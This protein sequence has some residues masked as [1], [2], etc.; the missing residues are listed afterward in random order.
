MHVGLPH[1][2]SL[3]AG[4]LCTFGSRCLLRV[5][6]EPVAAEAPAKCVP[7]H[8]AKLLER[9]VFSNNELGRPRRGVFDLLYAVR[10]RRLGYK[11]KLQREAHFPPRV[12][13]RL[14]LVGEKLLP[15]LSGA[16]KQSNSNL[17]G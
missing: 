17:N 6:Q 10:G 4:L 9:Q 5:F 7:G 13:G 16:H 3:E 1:F 14:G 15:H 12:P 2:G 11:V 8:R